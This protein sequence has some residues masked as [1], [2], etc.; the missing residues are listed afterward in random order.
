[1]DNLLN[2]K[3]YEEELMQIIQFKGYF[4]LQTHLTRQKKK[5]LPEREIKITMDFFLKKNH[6]NSLLKWL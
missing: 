1:M 6:I 2:Q 5:K 4:P 3:Y